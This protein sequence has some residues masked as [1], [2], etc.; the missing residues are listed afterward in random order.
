MTLH[1]ALRR[2][3]G[4]VFLLVFWVLAGACQRP[5]ARRGRAGRKFR[6]FGLIC[7]KPGKRLLL[8]FFSHVS[9]IFWGCVFSF[10]LCVFV[11]FG[12][13]F[14][15]FRALARFFFSFFFS[16]LL[17]LFFAL[18]QAKPGISALW[19]GSNF[20]IHHHLHHHPWGAARARRRPSAAGEGARGRAVR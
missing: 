16:V 12:G 18:S 3:A 2:M 15:V 6:R 19:A 7:A 17:E 1:R 20:A 10:F 8:F 13:V 11:L 14:F 5:K 9:A 4:L